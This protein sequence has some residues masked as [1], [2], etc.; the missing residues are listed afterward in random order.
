MTRTAHSRY[1]H[2]KE[3]LSNTR[4]GI[5]VNLGM[6][7]VS[8][9]QVL[10]AADYLLTCYICKVQIVDLSYIT[11][12][13]FDEVPRVH[14]DPTKMV[15]VAILQVHITSTGKKRKL[16]E[17]LWKLK[18]V[19]NW[20]VYTP[21]PIPDNEHFSWT[22][23]SPDLAWMVYYPP[24]PLPRNWK[25]LIKYLNFR[26]GQEDS[27]SVFAIASYLPWSFSFIYKKVLQAGVNRIPVRP[28]L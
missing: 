26:F 2:E 19:L 18:R 25:L 10:C 14:V 27:A 24:P 22:T 4:C 12:N 20:M 5:V 6:N 1:W 16:L 17:I 28:A 11:A 23:W 8:M 9:W 7:D 21:F 15:K 3:G 13:W